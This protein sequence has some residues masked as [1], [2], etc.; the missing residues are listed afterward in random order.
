MIQRAFGEKR[1]ANSSDASCADQRKRDPLEIQ[2]AVLKKDQ[3]HEVVERK[4]YQ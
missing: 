4:F 2:R 3:I 1:F